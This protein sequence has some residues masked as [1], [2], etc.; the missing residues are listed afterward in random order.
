MVIGMRRAFLRS[1]VLLGSIGAAGCIDG[2][3]PRPRPG[4]IDPDDKPGNGR[5]E[6]QW[7]ETQPRVID[8][9]VT[10]SVTVNVSVSGT[11]RSV[12]L[13]MRSGQ[14]IEL[15]RVDDL[16]R[17]RLAVN[18][19]MF[20]YRL[21]DLHQ[22]VAFIEISTADSISEHRVVMNVRDETVPFINVTAISPGIQ[23]S[24]HVLNIRYDGVAPGSP[25]P[26]SIVRTFYNSFPDDF[27]FIAVVE[28]VTSNKPMFYTAVRNNTGGIGL[29]PFDNGATYGSATTLEGIIQYPNATDLDLARTDNIHEIAHRWMNYLEQPVLSPGR[30]HWPLSTLAHGITGWKDPASGGRLLFPYDLTQLSNGTFAV[31]VT[32]TPRLFN[33]MELYLMGLLPPDSVQP[34][35]VFADQNQQSQL[36]DGGIL[37]GQVDTVRIAQVIATNGA[38][39]PAA[40]TAQ[41]EFK[42]AT[43]VLTRGGILT[44]EEFAFFEHV[45]ARG[46]KTLALP[47]AN[48]ITRGTT[49]PFFLATGGRATL[50]TRIRG[51]R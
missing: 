7:F 49:Q 50:S 48:G 45:A 19:L 40:G 9:G 21:G 38:R 32:E 35:I 11:P 2:I 10:D 30:P 41:R 43:I 16:Y 27:H 29:A 5:A 31:R 26:A 8:L 24:D 51:L 14:P 17:G 20:G 44:R 3:G 37:R 1:L 15:R 4:T 13:V 6:F 18:N 36:R 25:L 42:M 39:T 34:H 22:T 28:A 47:F 23:M 33:D 46:E 12:H